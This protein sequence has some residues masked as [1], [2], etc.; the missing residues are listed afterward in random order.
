MSSPPETAPTLRTFQDVR[1]TAADTIRRVKARDLTAD[2]ARSITALLSLAADTVV[3]EET[4]N[5][6]LVRNTT[7]TPGVPATAPPPP[8]ASKN[9]EG[10]FILNLNVSGGA[11]PTITVDEQRTHHP[12]PAA[13]PHQPPHIEVWDSAI[14]E[15][16][17]DPGADPDPDPG[18]DSDPGVSLDMLARGKM[19]AQSRADESNE[20][21]KTRSAML[22]RL[23]RQRNT[24]VGGAQ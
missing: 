3:K 18:A 7:D 22:S 10:T 5:R 2:Q 24:L 4:L 21:T 15:P 12:E 14:H 1:D 19:L 13:A 20:T 9:T 16:E 8:R 23:M 11:N 17:P 6:A